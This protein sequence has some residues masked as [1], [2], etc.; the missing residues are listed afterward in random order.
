[1]RYTTAR[2]VRRRPGSTRSAGTSNGI[3]AALIFVRAR[4]S[5]RFMV[6][7]ATSKSPTCPTRAAR[8]RPH[9]SRKTLSS[10]ELALDHRSHLDRPAKP[11]GGH[12]SR[13]RQRLVEV[14]RVEDVVPAED[15]L[16][17]GERPVGQQ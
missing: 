8:T 5:R 7:S 3:P 12:P 4:D 14:V 11:C 1:M 17:L 2:T 16:G 13:E 6:S 15:L 10:K 9:S